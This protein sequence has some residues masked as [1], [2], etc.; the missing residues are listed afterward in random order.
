MRVRA[1][2]STN[3][4]GAHSL[5]LILQRLRKL[6]ET[7]LH[8]VR[9]HAVA[10]RAEE[11]QRLAARV[12]RLR[13]VAERR[14]AEREVVERVS[15]LLAVCARAY[16]GQRVAQERERPSVIGGR[17][18]A[19]ARTLVEVARLRERVAFDASARG[20]SLLLDCLLALLLS[21]LLLALGLRS[22]LVGRML[23][24]LRV[25]ALTLRL[26]ERGLQVGERA[27]AVVR[28]AVCASRL[29]ERAVA[30]RE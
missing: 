2:A 12:N 26:S 30:L 9:H 25:D 28:V 27:L 21:D 14:V 11:R 1:P 13:V 16:G 6:F 8:D 19:V 20:D 24:Q 17:A 7:N 4:S 5:L 29:F 10:Q 23:L 3:S 22:L 18:L 15:L